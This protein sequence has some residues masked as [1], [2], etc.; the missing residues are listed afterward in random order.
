[1]DRYWLLTSTTYGTWL[2]GDGRGF[3][4]N[5]RVGPGP[6]VRHNTPGTPFDADMPELQQ[7]A[8]SKL[9]GPPIRLNCQQA[10]TV[11]RQFRETAEHRGWQLLAAAVM[12]NHF[13]V[14]L[15][16][17]GDPDPHLLLRDLK[18]Y[19]SRRLNQSWTK[20]P[21]GTWWTE[22]GSVRKLPTESAVLAAIDYV[23]RQQNPLALWPPAD[24]TGE[25]GA[26]AP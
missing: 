19:A 5:V 12:G 13:H 1:M 24:P 2:P 11:L 6:E 26:S 8:M 17:S 20:P 18:S 15:G 23:R 14:V 16:V 9:Q 10:D 21:S 4:T 7:A 25:R 22:S 3:V